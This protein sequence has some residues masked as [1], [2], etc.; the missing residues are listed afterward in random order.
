MV[1]ITLHFE[2]ENGDHRSFTTGF[3]E[4]DIG[5]DFV[6]SDDFLITTNITFNPTG[7]QFALNEDGQFLHM[8]PFEFEISEHPTIPPKPGRPNKK[9][10]QQPGGG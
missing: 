3:S 10:T 7:K 4:D 6:L 8:F 2:D 5:P 1:S 9:A